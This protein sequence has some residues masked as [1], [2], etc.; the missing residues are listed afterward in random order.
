[1]AG[2]RLK[3]KQYWARV[4]MSRG[5]RPGE[6]NIPLRT[7]EKRTALLRL[8]EVEKVKD[9]IKQGVKFDFPWLDDTPIAKPKTYTLAEASDDYLRARE[10]DKL[11]P[12][13]IVSYRGEL[14][15]CAKAL[16]RDL[17][18][19]QINIE[20]IDKLK[21][22]WS[23]VG[24]KPTTINVALRSFRAFL[25]W[26]HDRNKLDR[27]P[28]IKLV[29][30]E[31][32]EPMYLS[33][34]QFDDICNATTSDLAQVFEFYR[35]TGL[36]LSEPFNATLNGNY[37]TISAEHAKGKRRRDVPLS[38]ESIETFKLLQQGKYKGDYLSHQFQR[39]AKKAGVA[40]RKFH[41]LR[42]TAALRHYL[43]TRDIY[44][45]MKLLGHADVKVTQIYAN[46][47]LG[48]LRED[49]P[50]L[51]DESEEIVAFQKR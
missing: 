31:S 12:R 24:Y 20:S 51:I 46:F 6:V 14:E 35:Q 37:L 29:S 7:A 36:R 33:N 34:K 16:G 44:L 40:G 10:A 28:R 45:V 18:V 22:H 13:T 9:L 15:K 26:L 50:D 8:A 23:E 5:S 2:L 49:F 47:E 39:A 17:E 43:K 41:S 42:H 3:K 30:G 4:Y 25:R 38:N 1:M 32:T 48:M 27:V 21:Q 11:R 19:S